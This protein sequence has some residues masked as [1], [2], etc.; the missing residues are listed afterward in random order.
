[1]RKEPRTS[2]SSFSCGCC[3]RS[4]RRVGIYKPFCLGG[5]GDGDE[6][7]VIKKGE[8]RVFSGLNTNNIRNLLFDDYKQL[9]PIKEKDIQYLFCLGGDGGGDDVEDYVTK[10]TI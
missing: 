5:D 8:R 2:S 1:M 7:D 4:Q 6:D 9:W 10:V 3:G